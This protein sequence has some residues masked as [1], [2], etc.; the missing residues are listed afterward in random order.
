MDEFKLEEFGKVSLELEC[1]HF[2]FWGFRLRGLWSALQLEK[3]NQCPR[4]NEPPA[5][6]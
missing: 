6:C 4:Q 3:E 2:P 5:L 1:S